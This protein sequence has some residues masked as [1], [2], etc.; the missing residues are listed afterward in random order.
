[1]SM[2]DREI[3]LGKIIRRRRAR[4]GLSQTALAQ[5][6]GITFQQ[7]QKYERGANRVHFARFLDLAS[8]LDTT[9]EALLEECRELLD[10]A[11]KSDEH[12]KPEDRD[13]VRLM[14]LANRVDA[15][16]R[17]AVIGLLSA[18]VRSDNAAS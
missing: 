1:M 9:P 8:A 18:R 4:V 13:A 3:A 10:E 17:R 14:G 11:P 12:A 5:R 15:E 7:I 6:I 16:T 2:D